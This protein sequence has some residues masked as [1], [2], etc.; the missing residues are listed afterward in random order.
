MAF[1]A[2]QS[3]KFSAA[4]PLNGQRPT[5]AGGMCHCLGEGAAKNAIFWCKNCPNL[6]KIAQIVK[7]ELEN[8]RNRGHCT[9]L[10]RPLKRRT[11]R[12][13]RA[14]RG[15][16]LAPTRR[17]ALRA[18]RRVARLRRVLIPFRDRWRFILCSHARS[19]AETA[20]GKH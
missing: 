16:A 8:G 14:A 6:P 20:A 5:G 10:K 12:G 13:V 15:G 18:N 17:F 7:I 19:A 9:A 3:P 2:L 1:W 11:P 4:Q